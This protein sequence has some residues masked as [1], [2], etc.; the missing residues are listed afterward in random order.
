MKCVRLVWVMYYVVSKLKWMNV[1][2]IRGMLVFLDDQAYQEEKVNRYDSS[3]EKQASCCVFYVFMDFF[4]RIGHHQASCVFIPG[5]HWTF[6][7][8]WHPW[9]RR[10]SWPQGMCCIITNFSSPNVKSNLFYFFGVGRPWFWWH[11][12]IQRSSG[13][14]RW[15]GEFLQCALYLFSII[16]SI[17]HP[18][19]PH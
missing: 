2:V 8:P 1:F 3:V 13:R 7:D 10:A 19:K 17:I 16:C 11:C 14:E 15:K 6:W 9:K 4:F 18:Q 12:G 5:G